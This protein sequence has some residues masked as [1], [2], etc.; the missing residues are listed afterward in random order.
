MW[1][2][3]TG[4][5][6]LGF[7]LLSG[8]LDITQARRFKDQLRSI[9][10]K[11]ESVSLVSVMHAD[12]GSLNIEVVS[13]H[14]ADDPVATAWVRHAQERAPELWEKLAARQKGVVRA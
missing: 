3:L 14:D 6:S 2:Y 10:E 4:H 5:T 7:S 13:Q 9:C 8:N 1:R 11:P 12:P